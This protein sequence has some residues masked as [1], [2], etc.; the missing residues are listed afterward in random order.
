MPGTAHSSRIWQLRH[1]CRTLPVG[2]TIMGILNTTPDSFSDG[3]EHMGISAAVQHAEQMLR[4]GADIIDI[5]G[6]STRPGATPTDIAT[7]IAR[8]IPVI[9]ALREKHPTLLLS[10]DTRHAEVASAALEAG[11]DIINDIS[12][13][14]D[15]AMVQLCA[16]HD[17]GIILMHSLPFEGELPAPE[18]MPALIHHFFE[19]RLQTLAA[20]GIAPERICLDPGIGFGK[21]A[22]HS[23]EII[24]RLEEIRVANRPILMALSRKRFIGELL[25]GQPQAVHEELPTVVLSLISAQ[26]GADLHRV[27]DISGLRKALTLLSAT[28]ESLPDAIR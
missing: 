12:A 5:G 9:R 24:R 1:S 23:V 17:C 3:G 15:R 20:A 18:E 16:A 11:A 14:S 28:S 21:K 8:T 7:E 19:E 27:H 6:E 13:L 2:G 26:N 22:A 25:Y 4:E 10:I